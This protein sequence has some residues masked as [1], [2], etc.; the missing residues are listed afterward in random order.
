MSHLPTETEFRKIQN[1]R[2]R[3][4]QQQQQQQPHLFHSVSYSR[5]E[6]KARTIQANKCKKPVIIETGDFTLDVDD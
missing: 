2:Q 6:Y 3:H 1:L 5:K 4:H